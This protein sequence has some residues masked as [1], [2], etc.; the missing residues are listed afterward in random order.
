MP[1][2]PV[3]TTFTKQQ[4]ATAAGRFNDPTKEIGRLLEEL[5]RLRQ[6]T[7]SINL[8]IN[9]GDMDLV[10]RIQEATLAPALARVSGGFG[11]RGL[12]GSSLEAAQ[13]AQV[14]GQVGI[15]GSQMLRDMPFQRAEFEMGKNRQLYESLIGAMTA[16]TMK[17]APGTQLKKKG[18]GFLGGLGGILGGIAGSALGPIGTAI[19]TKIGGSILGGAPQQDPYQTNYYQGMQSPY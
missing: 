18:G 15:A 6:S 10:Q 4:P 12:S 7:G 13:R 1:A 9:Q 2:N 5:E 8:G 19:G 3:F 17:G 16:T 14:A 11:A